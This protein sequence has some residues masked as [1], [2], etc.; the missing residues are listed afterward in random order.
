MLD[1][2]CAF[3]QAHHHSTDRVRI[4]CG[5]TTGVVLCGYHA[6]PAWLPEVLRRLER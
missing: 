5:T 1:N 2:P 4:Y 6:S 3:T